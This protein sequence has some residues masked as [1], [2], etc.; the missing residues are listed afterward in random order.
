MLIW[1]S[2]YTVVM[3][4]YHWSPQLGCDSLKHE[5]NWQQLE[6]QWQDDTGICCSDLQLISAKICPFHSAD[7]TEIQLRLPTSVMI[8]VPGSALPQLSGLSH[9]RT[10]IRTSNLMLGN[11]SAYPQLTNSIFQFPT[12]G[13]LLGTWT[14][15]LALCLSKQ[16]LFRLSPQCAQLKY[17]LTVAPLA[18]CT[19]G[20]ITC[21]LLG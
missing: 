19:Q 2:V 7:K 16:V 10:V 6:G 20:P 5:H 15:L 21:I 17:A 8:S 18:C 11:K 12:A 13:T 3:L 9:F 14:I 1:Q 4:N